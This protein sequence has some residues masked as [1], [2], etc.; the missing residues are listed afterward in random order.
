MSYAC[1]YDIRMIYTLYS[2]RVFAKIELWVGV[3]LEWTFFYPEVGDPTERGFQLFQVR[4][5]SPFRTWSVCSWEERHLSSREKPIQS[6]LVPRDSVAHYYYSYTYNISILC[7]YY[8]DTIMCRTAVHTS[9]SSRTPTTEDTGY[10]WYAN[11]RSCIYNLVYIY[12]AEHIIT[13][14]LVHEKVYWPKPFTDTPS[15]SSLV[16]RRQ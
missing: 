16:Q 3:D 15:V 10:V 8:Y 5:K 7:L 2:S 6:S 13:E 14:W 11:K 4:Q 9:Y 1:M 12:I